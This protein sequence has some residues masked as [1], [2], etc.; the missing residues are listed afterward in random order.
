MRT[1][2]S[3]CSA[4]HRLPGKF[5]H[6]PQHG[7][8][9]FC[10][11]RLQHQVRAI[12][13]DQ[14]GGRQSRQKPASRGRRNHSIV[15]RLEHQGRDADPGKRR[16]VVDRQKGGD[17]M[18]NHGGRHSRDGP[19]HLRRR[20]SWCGRSPHQ[21]RTHPA[22]QRLQRQVGGQRPHPP[23]PR[24]R[25]PGE[26]SAEDHAEQTLGRSCS[27]PDGDGSGE[28]LAQQNKRL[29][30]RQLGQHQSLELVI[31]QGLRQRIGHDA[32]FDARTQGSYELAEQF[33]RAVESRQQNQCGQGWRTIAALRR[34]VHRTLKSASRRARRPRWSATSNKSR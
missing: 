28:G 19:I 9:T 23:R 11:T 24:K 14:L 20:A 4:R 12:D 30:S 7:G 6:E 21:R 8:S 22:R 34:S 18:S 5:S 15:P 13:L 3:D 16:A 10:R 32:R 29:I 17:S 1:R 26:S 33:S 2:S 27:Y 31:A 25:I